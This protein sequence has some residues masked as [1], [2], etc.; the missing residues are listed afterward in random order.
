MKTFLSLSF[1]SLA[2]ALTISEINGVKFLSPYAGQVVTNVTGLVTA[3]GS[4]G[5]Y[6]RSTTPDTD[7]RSSN[8]IYVYNTAAAKTVT[9]GDIVNLGGTVAE[10]RSSSAYM[11]LTEITSPKNIT[12]LSKNNTVTPLVIGKQTTSPPTQQFS[13]FDNGD[14]YSLPG[15]SSQISKANP[16]LQPSK[17]G[18]DFWESLTG[19]LVTVSKPKV[20]TRPNSYLDIW[21]TGDWK[22]TGRN[23]RGGLT[24]VDKGQ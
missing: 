19:E 17:Y 8:S 13:S 16:E 9:V 23:K 14:I 18:M 6:L 4:S 3:K 20:I 5:F 10:Y 1:A 2:S 21:V 22:V 12:I 7:V 11:Y 15:N 24:M